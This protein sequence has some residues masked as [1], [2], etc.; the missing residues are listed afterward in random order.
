M[1][2]RT[3]F[4]CMASRASDKTM[5]FHRIAQLRGKISQNR[6]SPA[7]RF[8][9]GIPFVRLAADGCAASGRRRYRRR[10]LLFK[11]VKKRREQKP[12]GR[13]C[14]AAEC[15]FRRSDGLAGRLRRRVLRRVQASFRRHAQPNAPD[16]R[17]LP[18]RRSRVVCGRIRSPRSCARQARCLRRPHS[19]SLLFRAAFRHTSA[20][21]PRRAAP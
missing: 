16:T 9:V 17:G 13:N 18:F 21:P 1:F 10:L 8:A 14:S 5:F 6:Y 11:S 3:F 7:V 4:A 19:G 20:C 2:F 12:G 15:R